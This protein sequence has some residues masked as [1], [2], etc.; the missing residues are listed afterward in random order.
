MKIHYSALPLA[1]AASAMALTTAC[2]STPEAASADQTA[3]SQE[4]ASSTTSSPPASAAPFEGTWRAG[5]FLLREVHQ[6]LRQEDLG[7][8]TTDIAEGRPPTTELVYD[9]KLQGGGL[10]L[11]V[12]IDGETQ[13]VWDRQSYTTDGRTIAFSVENGTCS[14]TF[15]W[16]VAGDLLTFRLL[17]D[18]CPDYEGTPDSAYMETL[19]ASVPYRRMS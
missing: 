2:D 1:V 3:A 6:H 9:L 17:K 7:Q 11:N 8:W 14:S 16:D 19:Y 13:G 10:L 4:S 15:R 12:T 5:P 18:T